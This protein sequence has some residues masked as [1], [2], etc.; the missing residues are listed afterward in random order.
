M[1]IASIPERA[2]VGIEGSEA[3]AGSDPAFHRPVILRAHELRS[4]PIGIGSAAQFSCLLELDD[5]LRI[6]GVPVDARIETSDEGV[7]GE[8]FGERFGGRISGECL[9]CSFRSMRQ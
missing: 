5:S 1:F 7:Q 2:P 3:L 9:D 4:E 6:R 8:L